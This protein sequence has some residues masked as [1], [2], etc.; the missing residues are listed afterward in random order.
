MPQHTEDILTD[1]WRNDGEFAALGEEAGAVAAAKSI[2][3]ALQE[4]TDRGDRQALIVLYQK[5]L[6]IHTEDPTE[7]AP[8]RGEPFPTWAVHAVVGMLSFT[9]CLALVRLCLLVDSDR[10]AAQGT[11]REAAG[12]VGG[13]SR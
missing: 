5:S 13:D 11:S 8:S 7:R 2:T 1:F 12:S 10:P 3:T 6:N 4:I 9:L